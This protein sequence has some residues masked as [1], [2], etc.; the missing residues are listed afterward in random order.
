MPSQSE[1]KPFPVRLE[2][3]LRERVKEAGGSR[4][5]RGLIQIFF[6]LKLET[7]IDEVAGI[8]EELAQMEAA[9]LK[10]VEM[11]DLEFLYDSLLSV[12]RWNKDKLKRHQA[13]SMLGRVEWLK[14][15]KMK[16]TRTRWS[17]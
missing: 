6:G 3:E 11:S 2:P 16:K 5:V 13:V 14:A 9:P 7:K 1:N 15:R 4:L 10:K 8:E 12:L 17:R